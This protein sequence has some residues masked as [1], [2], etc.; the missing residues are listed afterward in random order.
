MPILNLSPGV[1]MHYRIDDFTDPWSAPETILLL[2]G[3]AESGESWFAWAPHLARRFRVVRPDMRGFGDSTPM[4]RD[5]PWSLDRVIDDLLRLMD[6]IGAKRFHLVGAKLGGTIA[7]ALAG[8]HPDRVITLSAIGTP[9]PTRTKTPEMV[10]AR[11]QFCQDHNF[12]KSARER[13]KLRL[14]TAFSADGA[15]WW[16]RFMARTP[17]STH[18]GWI[19]NISYSDIGP[20]LPRI[21]CPTLVM[22]TEKSD[23]GSVEITRRWQEMIPDSRL[24][25]VP[26]D[27]YHVAASHADM[28]ARTV[29]DFI[30]ECQR[31]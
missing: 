4:P 7:R 8:R 3:T 17:D 30:G 25:V 2:H 11:V 29:I 22:V 13:M 26:G 20:D 16:A 24:V 21:S 27:S 5:F 15:E 9:P 14:G 18:A 12:E 10:A 1:H 31:K 23:L 19:E 6:S 28:C